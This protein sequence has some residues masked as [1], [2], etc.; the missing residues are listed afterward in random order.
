MTPGKGRLYFRLVPERRT[1][2]LAF[3]GSKPG[4]DRLSN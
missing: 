4:S 2:R 1:F 3:V